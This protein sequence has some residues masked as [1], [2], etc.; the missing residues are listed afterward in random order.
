[1]NR[2]ALEH[3]LRAAA[4]VANERDLVVIGSQAVLGQFP[5]AP[6]ALL[7]SI[8]ADVFPRHAPEKSDLI[9]GAIGELSG[10]HQTFG[11]YAHGV[12][13]TTAT[14]PAGWEDRLVPIHNENTAGATG[15]CLEVHDLAVSK[16]VAGREKDLAFLQVLLRETMARPGVL[17]DR[18][19]VLPVSADHM[20]MLRERL[21]RMER[22]SGIGRDERRE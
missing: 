10:F 12:D 3:I 6:D 11:Y 20:E 14:L 13:D 2:A 1:M 9:D 16:L 5:D 22:D 7:A 15:W 19:S 17:R 21:R 4:A 18:L 8:E